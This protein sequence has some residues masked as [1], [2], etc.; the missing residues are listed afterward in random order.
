MVTLTMDSS[1]SPI[2]SSTKA[3]PPALGLSRYLKGDFCWAC[4]PSVKRVPSTK[5]KIPTGLSR[6]FAQVLR[7]VSRS[8]PFF[9]GCFS[10]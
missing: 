7:V 4:L 10:R 3:M 6:N 8:L 5:L 2:A 1:C 9:S